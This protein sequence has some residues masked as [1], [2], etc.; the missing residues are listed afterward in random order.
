V[1]G[2]RR[3]LN[4]PL[5]GSKPLVVGRKRGDLILD[6]PLK[7]LDARS[8]SKRER[9]NDFFNHTLQSRLNDQKTGAIIVV[10]QRLHIDDLTGTL[11]RDSS[12]DS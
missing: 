7:S 12:F 10:T 2:V 3:G 6:D 1:S 4:V 11:L 9:V 5:H 8:D